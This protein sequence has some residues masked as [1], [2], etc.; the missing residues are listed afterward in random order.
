MKHTRFM[1][2]LIAIGL[3]AV[4]L[5]TAGVE[6]GTLVAIGAVIACPLMMILMMGGGM[7]RL[8]H[9]RQAGNEPADT[10]PSEDATAR[11]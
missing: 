10:A 11:S 4:V 8:G 1:P 2:C 5:I 3:A 6:A 7:H 9:R